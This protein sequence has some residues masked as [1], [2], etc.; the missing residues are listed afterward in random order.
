MTRLRL[1]YAARH[2]LRQA[3]AKKTIRRWPQTRRGVDDLT[4]L[5]FL[6]EVKR[7][8][9]WAVYSIT[10]AGRALAEQLPTSDE[11][12]QDMG[13]SE[14]RHRTYTVDLPDETIQAL[15]RGKWRSVELAD[16]G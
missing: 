2:A 4:R 9:R 6:A 5:G 13:T 11:E 12:W 7:T 8:D 15:R 16:G 14:L 3:A 1:D 10:D